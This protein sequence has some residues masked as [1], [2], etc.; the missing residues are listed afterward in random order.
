MLAVQSVTKS[1]SS[2]S[3]FGSGSAW[4]NGNNIMAS[5]NAYATS[6]ILAGGDSNVLNPSFT[7]DATDLPPGAIIVGVEVLIEH[8]DDGVQDLSI[9]DLE[10][11]NGTGA[12]N[13]ALYFDTHDDLAHPTT[14]DTIVTAGGKYDLIE[15]VNYTDFNLSSIQNWIDDAQ[16]YIQYSNPGGSSSVISVDHVQLRLYYVIALRPDLGT[17]P[18]IGLIEGTTAA[19]VSQG[20]SAWANPTNALTSNNVYAT[21]AALQSN[22]L[23]DYLTIGGFDFSA[24]PDNAEIYGFEIEI[25]AKISAVDVNWYMLLFALSDITSFSNAMYQRFSVGLFFENTFSTSDSIQT[26]GGASTL[27]SADTN[28]YSGELTP[29]IIK[30]ANFGVAIAFL[31]FGATGDRTISIDRVRAKVYYLASKTYLTQTKS[32]GTFTTEANGGTED[33]V[34][35]SNAGSSNNAYAVATLASTETSYALK[36]TNLGFSIPTNARIRRIAII[37]E[38]KDSA[39]F[40]DNLFGGVVKDGELLANG[41]Y[42]FGGL[43]AGFDASDTILSDMVFLLEYDLSL[44]NEVPNLGYTLLPEDIN[45]SDFGIWVQAN[46]PSGGSTFSI[47]HIQVVVEYYLTGRTLDQGRIGG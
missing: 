44:V 9:T 23:T 17:V 25:E 10:I 40:E 13:T 3:S 7:F 4:V 21:N 42:S 14:S 30:G 22:G 47:D 38:A 19:N 5:D 20:A 32:P 46:D 41:V 37:V 26:V 15:P 11:V 29:A 34:N 6:T 27:W 36:A 8:K 45:K 28:Y 2:V 33:W 1:P 31:D 43:A 39:G 18:S 35:P 24:L 12:I 16:L